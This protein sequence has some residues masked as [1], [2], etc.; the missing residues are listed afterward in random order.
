[1]TSEAKRETFAAVGVIV[2]MVFVGL[3]IRQSNVQAKAA[4]YQSIGIATQQ[5]FL[6]R[7]ARVIRLYTEADY[8]EALS[9]WTL[10]DWEV[11][12]NDML[13]GLRMMETVQL[14]V[15]QD[16]LDREAM[17]S[18]GYSLDD[19]QALATPGFVCL[20]PTIRGAVG[21]ALRDLIDGSV[22]EYGFECPIDVQSLRDQVA[23]SSMGRR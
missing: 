8:P 15:S 1:M 5:Y 22:Q 20:W 9:R 13:S 6:N 12:S 11:Y 10:G 18:L 16:L 2:S 23:D 21:A 7:G 17:E 14:Q 3:Q 19:H 4:A